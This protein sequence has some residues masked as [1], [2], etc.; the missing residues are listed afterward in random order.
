MPADARAGFAEA[1]AGRVALLGVGVGD[2]GNATAGRAL[3]SAVARLGHGLLR[4]FHADVDLGVTGKVFAAAAAGRGGVCGWRVAGAEVAVA[5][6]AVGF[7]RCFLFGFWRPGID[8]EV[9]RGVDFPA[10]PA[11]YGAVGLLAAVGRGRSVAVGITG[12]AGSWASGCRIV[13]VEGVR[14]ERDGGGWR[15]LRGDG[16]SRRHSA[17]GC[18]C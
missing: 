18:L 8:G 1:R 11:D 10:V 9:V 7:G 14:G 16:F 3:G 2:W 6:E 12:L 5:A 13:D 15:W 17:Y 4:G